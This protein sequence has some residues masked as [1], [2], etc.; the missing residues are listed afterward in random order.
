MPHLLPILCKYGYV[1]EAYQLLQQEGSPSWNYLFS[2]GSTTLAEGWKTLYENEDGRL[3]INGS[4]NHLGLGSVGQW[5]YTDILGIRRDEE[6]PAYQHFY[7]EPQV[8]G[9][10]TYA[11]GSYD[12][13]YGK[14]ESS[15]EISEGETE[16]HFTIPANTTATVTLPHKDYQNME[17]GSGTYHF[18]LER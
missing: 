11:E 12:S 4:L 9:G 3:V 7:L 6:H 17:L 10:L 5:F 14:I 2:Q 8:G 16:F 1:E 15:W 18:R 13:M